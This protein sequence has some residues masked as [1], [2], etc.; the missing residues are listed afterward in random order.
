MAEA[1]D[2]TV[3]FENDRERGVFLADLLYLTTQ[4]DQW[5]DWALNIEAR[6]P[7]SVVATSRP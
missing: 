3:P 6:R 5:R 7:P 2:L 4:L 1:P